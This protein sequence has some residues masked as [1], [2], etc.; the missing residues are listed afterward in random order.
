MFPAQRT[1]IKAHILINNN[2]PHQVVYTQSSDGNIPILHA[3]RKIL[4]KPVTF[5]T[6][7]RSVMARGAGHVVLVLFGQKLQAKEMAFQ[8]AVHF[9]IILRSLLARLQHSL[10]FEHLLSFTSSTTEDKSGRKW[11]V[12]A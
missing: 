2:L 11:R 7:G 6:G 10:K 4:N 9:H 1:V 12:E 3:N 5:T 8:T